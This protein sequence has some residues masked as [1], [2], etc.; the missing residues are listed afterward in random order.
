MNRETTIGPQITQAKTDEREARL[1]DEY[2]HNNPFPIL[3]PQ[4]VSPIEDAP[5]NAHTIRRNSFLS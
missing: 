2:Q 3:A 4:A 5:R 1:F